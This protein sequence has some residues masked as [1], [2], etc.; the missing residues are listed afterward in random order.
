MES[1]TPLWGLYGDTRRGVLA[2]GLGNAIGVVYVHK[3]SGEGTLA[4]GVSLGEQTPSPHRSLRYRLNLCG[5]LDR[6]RLYA[7]DVTSVVFEW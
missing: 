7:A 5:P 4:I 6:E 3:R 1:E 2:V